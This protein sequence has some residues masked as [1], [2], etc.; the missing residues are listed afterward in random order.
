[1]SDSDDSAVSADLANKSIPT[2][3]KGRKKLADDDEPWEKDDEE[4]V[5]FNDENHYMSDQQDDEEAVSTDSDSF[6]HDDEAGCEVSE[7]VTNL[8]NPTIA[9]GVTFE[10]GNTFKSAIMQFV[11]L[12]E[13]EIAGPYSEAK[14]YRGYCKGTK[15]KKKRCKSR[16]HASQLQ[17]GKTWQVW[18]FLFL[19]L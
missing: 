17:D 9:V 6:V 11:V 12:N 15:S 13:F 2:Q 19:F 14:R 5:R 18:S 10:D 8:E 16:I 3:G 4:Y 7:H 1:M